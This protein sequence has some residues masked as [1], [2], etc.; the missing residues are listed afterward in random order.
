MD[1]DTSRLFSSLSLHEQV[2]IIAALLR[3]L[4]LE[5]E[6]LPPERPEYYAGFVAMYQMVLYTEIAG[7][8]DIQRSEIDREQEAEL[9]KEQ[10]RRGDADF[11]AWCEVSAD[12]HRQERIERQS[13]LDRLCPD[14]MEQSYLQSMRAEC[15]SNDQMQQ[16]ALAVLPELQEKMA[17]LS[18]LPKEKDLIKQMAAFDQRVTRAKTATLGQGSSQP[19][20]KKK[21]KD[22]GA[23]D[24]AFYWR[25]L[26]LNMQSE[27]IGGTCMPGKIKADCADMEAWEAAAYF[28]M[29]AGCIRLST[30]DHAL[31]YGPFNG[32]EEEQKEYEDLIHA[33][34]RRRFEIFSKLWDP[35]KVAFDELTVQVLSSHAH[36]PPVLHPWW[37]A[38]NHRLQCKLEQDRLEALE[39]ELNGEDT[40]EAARGRSQL[41]P[42]LFSCRPF[43]TEVQQDELKHQPLSTRIE[44]E[45]ARDSWIWIWHDLMDGKDLD[46]DSPADRYHALLLTRDIL[47]SQNIP[48]EHVGTIGLWS[49]SDWMKSV[50]DDLALTCSFCYS[51]ILPSLET[52]AITC[53]GCGVAKYCKSSCQD[54]DW[55]KEYMPHREACAAMRLAR[56]DPVAFRSQM[57]ADRQEARRLAETEVQ[58]R[59]E[60]QVEAA[61]KEAASKAAALLAPAQEDRDQNFASEALA[62]LQRV[63]KARTEATTLR[64]IPERNEDLKSALTLAQRISIKGSWP[65]ELRGG[66][67]RSVAEARELLESSSNTLQQQHS[68][69]DV[70]LGGPSRHKGPAQA[71]PG[72]QAPGQATLS[73]RPKQADEVDAT[74]SKREKQK[75]RRSELKRKKEVE[76]AHHAEAEAALERQRLY[77]L[78]PKVWEA[79]EG[80]AFEGIQEETV[81]DDGEVVITLPS[82][83]SNA[84]A[85]REGL[86][87]D[88][89]RKLWAEGQRSPHSAKQRRGRS[90]SPDHCWR[91]SQ[92]RGLKFSLAEFQARFAGADSRQRLATA[93]P[94]DYGADLS[95][96]VPSCEQSQA[97]SV[98]EVGVEGFMDPRDILF[99]HSSISRCFRNGAALDDT[100]EAV[101]KGEI[102]LTAFPAMEV[103]DLDGHYFCLSNRRLF[104]HR[105]LANMGRCQQARV[106][107]LSWNS[108]R[109]QRLRWDESLGRLATKWERSLSTKN[110][111]RLVRIQSKFSSLQEPSRASRDGLLQVRS[112]VDRAQSAHR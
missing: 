75:R 105:V 64:A 62:H 9:W 96:A 2:S 41:S 85:F 36:G 65:D 37:P 103:I 23:N 82:K 17:S 90:S 3:G 61:R 1:G 33:R 53:S 73:K 97:D 94:E 47:N 108:E 67:A 31:V 63:M 5:A 57:E 16:R 8:V 60:E 45:Q 40:S 68:E 49:P 38:E 56:S 89:A 112:A 12:V 111:G 66:F 76:L 43:M 11:H 91:G 79:A 13:R 42:I 87:K 101:L 102:E 50:S 32:K 71:E 20:R 18:M 70:K 34:S 7:E 44:M 10:A 80:D 110:G 54:A 59:R 55:T 74:P 4:L 39:R 27:R 104:L 29:T 84:F 109:V 51:K 14:E 35:A 21:H 83:T 72:R 107:P 78:H 48:L 98:L 93:G 19:S 99:T 77:N 100:I 46:Y 106:V 30:E 92:A 52:Q 28:F 26:F 15:D 58:K 24:Y 88:S 22:P 69:G 6:P 81:L 95:E 86:L 25:R